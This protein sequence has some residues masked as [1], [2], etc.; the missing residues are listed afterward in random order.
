[1][2][3]YIR[4]ATSADLPAMMAIIEQGKHA[5]AADQIPQWQDGYPLAA[6]IQADIDARIAWVL[7]VDDQIAGTAALLTT[8][9]PNTLL[10]MMAAG[11]LL[12]TTA[13]PRF[14]VLLL[15]MVTTDNIWLTFTLAISLPWV[16]NSAFVN[17]ELIRTC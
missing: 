14:T 5:L 4:Q 9:D 11:R 8:P 12:R 3:K 16:T 13:M 15:P 1:M 10:F 7:I 17:S 6:D 2:S